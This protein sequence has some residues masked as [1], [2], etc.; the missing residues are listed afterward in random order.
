MT[1]PERVL[2]GVRAAERDGRLPPP[3]LEVLGET[4]PFEA[5]TS[6]VPVPD[7][8]PEPPRHGEDAG[9][10]SACA[11]PDDACL[12]SDDLWRVRAP[13]QP[14]GVHALFLEPREHADL[15]DLSSDALDAMGRAQRKVVDAL[16]AAL[17]GVERVHVIRWGDG[18]AHLHW[19]FL[20]RP[21]G[22]LQL[23]GSLLGLWLDVL[24]PLP[25]DAWKADLE[26]V[27]TALR[28]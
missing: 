16:H 21:A 7:L 12:W 1:Y 25:E 3:D 14:F 5:P 2:A 22:L 6:V 15:E 20:A 9:S 27:R 23:R 8:Q 19:W 13:G 24:P 11:A 10:C 26:R 17:D 4:W 18:A 28:S